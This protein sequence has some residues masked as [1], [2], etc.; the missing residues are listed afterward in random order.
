MKKCT[1]KR[2][3]ST[4][5]EAIQAADKYMDEIALVLAP[6]APYRCKKHNCYHIGHNR[7]MNYDSVA[8][9]STASRTRG[10]SIRRKSDIGRYTCDVSDIIEP[11]TGHRSARNIP[12]V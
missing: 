9:Y 1:L 8:I 4:L 6:M 7:Y 11:M 2:Q 10:N 5:C 3:F 12:N